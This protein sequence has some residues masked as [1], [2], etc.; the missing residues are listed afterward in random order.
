MAIETPE[1]HEALVASL[2]QPVRW[3]QGGEARRRIDTHISS[4]VLAGDL[5]YKLKKPLDLGFLDFLSLQARHRACL[6]EL[7]LNRR[8]APQIYLRVSAVTGSIEAPRIDGDGPVIDWAVCM[9]RF[10]P[11]AIL[12][13]LVDRIDGQLIETLATEVARFHQTIARCDPAASFGSA[14]AAYAPMTQNL[15][16]IERHVPKTAATL[17]PLKAW[18][19]AQRRRLG[20]VLEARKQAGHVRECHGDLHLGNVA[21]IDDRPVVFDAIEFNPGLRWIDTISDTAFMTMDLQERARPDLAYRYLSRYLQHT[22]DYEGLSVLRFYEVY[23]ALVRAKIAAIRVG[24]SDLDAPTRRSVC[25]E[26]DAYLAFARRLTVPRHG[27]VIIT[28]GVSGSGKSH[29]SRSLP[30]SLPAVCLRSDLERKRLLGVDPV[31]DATEHGAYTPESTARTYARLD[32]LTREVVG[33]GYVAVVD[34]TFL[35]RAQRAGFRDLAASLEVPFVIIDCDAP[36]EVLRERLLNRRERRDNVSDAD[37]AVLEMQLAGREPL[38]PEE[39]LRCIAVRPDRPL[40]VARLQK[41]LLPG[42]QRR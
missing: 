42:V 12:S 11:D 2:M 10:D 9:R 3:P 15:A 1:Q 7:R 23:R 30:D 27:A 38:A 32:S 6:E 36:P 24:Q 4:V 8:L 21:L 22:G 41:M 14:D 39:S 5:A 26:L 20:S 19:A 25:A 35:R 16:H 18:T 40:A 37:L 34:A 13:R 17:A 31:S 33:A 28:V 29:L